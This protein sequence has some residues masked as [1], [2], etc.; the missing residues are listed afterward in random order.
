MTCKNLRICKTPDS[1]CYFNKLPFPMMI[2]SSDD[3][4]GNLSSSAAIDACMWQYRNLSFAVIVNGQCPKHITNDYDGV[5]SKTNCLKVN[6][7]VLFK[8]IYHLGHQ[9]FY[10][11][12]LKIIEHHLFALGKNNFVTPIIKLSPGLQILAGGSYLDL[13]FAYDILHRKKQ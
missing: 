5:V 11:T 8:R 1:S 6:K 13:S 7:A 10:D 9:L 3:D 2:A 12:S 4:S